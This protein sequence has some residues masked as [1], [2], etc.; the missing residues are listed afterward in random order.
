VTP[1]PATDPIRLAGELF[2][3]R[4]W[5]REQ[6]LE[7]QRRTLRA[8][9]AHAATES[10]YYRE[11]LGSLANEDDVSLEDLPTL[12]KSVLMDEWDRV[13]ADP[14]LRLA[15]VEEYL[16]L[17][18][19]PEPYLGEY[20]V[21]TT[22][23]STGMRGVFVNGRSDFELTMAGMLRP[24][25]EFGITPDLRLLSIGSP[26][27]FH[28]SNQVFA[29]LRAG[30]GGSPPLDVTMPLD[31]IVAA[32]GAY[33]PEVI[34]SYPSIL[35]LLAEEQLDGRLSIAPAVAVTG[36]EALSDEV[37]TRVREAWGIETMDVY[38]STEGG[39]M[40]GECRERC[41]RH[42]WEDVLMLEPVDEQNRPVPPGVPS[43]RV[44][45]TNL[46]C[47]AQPLIRYE[48]ADSVTFAAGPNPTGR[49]YARIE[50]IEGRSSDIIH[51]PAR[52]GGDVAVHPFHLRAPFGRLPEVRQYQIQRSEDALRVS[53][54][55]HPAAG[56]DVPARV[57]MALLASIEA[58]GAV[59][60]RVEVEP[61]DE[62]TRR[63]AGAK[64]TL[65]A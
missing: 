51:L 54:V 19:L 31:D 3:R 60:P 57:E 35:G 20:R 21:F 26:S 22:G 11:T 23:G 61:V 13:V 5:S 59:P 43:H 33:Q 56:R 1:E 6:L 40:A 4:S 9:V 12:P 64:L 50:R 44:L 8:L 52:D 39:M 32:A 53:V 18:G 25:L 2:A 24:I 41:G 15:E 29:A 47:R 17:D 34:T 37:R 58:A 16:A 28:L 7:H 48:L 14:R 45:L 27:P 65:V 42:V 49:P 63:G 30:R 10:P 46:W 55:L 62:I 36:S 38:V